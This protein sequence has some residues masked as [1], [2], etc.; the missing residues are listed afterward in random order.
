MDRQAF[1]SVLP[2]LRTSR[3][4]LLH[5]SWRGWRVGR[6]IDSTG[7]GREF[8]DAVRERVTPDSGKFETV[9]LVAE[10]ADPTVIEKALD[11]AIDLTGIECVQKLVGLHDFTYGVRRQSLSRLEGCLELEIVTGVPLRTCLARSRASQFVSR[12]Q[13][14]DAA[15]LTLSGSGVPWRP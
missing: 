11:P 10:P 14:C 1:W 5:R 13:P 7:W 3:Q 4:P 8:S 12:T 2:T 6:C 9:H 15:L